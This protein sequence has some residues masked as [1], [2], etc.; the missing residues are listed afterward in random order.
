MSLRSEQLFSDAIRRS[1]SRRHTSSSSQSH[2]HDTPYLVT[3]RGMRLS[4]LLCLCC[5]GLCC[6]RRSAR[7]LAFWPPYPPT[8]YYQCLD[9]DCWKLR[10]FPTAFCPY[11]VAEL[12]T[13]F[14][15]DA[16]KVKSS[17]GSWIA[18]VRLTCSNRPQYTILRSHMNGVD[19]GQE[20]G[21]AVKLGVRCRCNVVLYDYSGYGESTGVPSE[22]NMCADISSVLT[23]LGPRYGLEARNVVLYGQSIGS[24][25]TIDLATKV[26]VAG[27]ILCSP[28][29]S[30]L[31]IVF[32]WV[33]GTSAFDSFA[34][35][36]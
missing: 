20:I 8:Y 32:P 19:I 7:T 27:V 28:L 10:L 21:F 2:S 18:C 16:F 3:Y 14:S 17:A 34:K 24:V 36:V 12:E 30:A 26:Y 6:L 33:K 25:P 29:F 11:T 22:E 35:S 4:D 31:R 5:C 9:A 15:M 23:E 1:F 13:V